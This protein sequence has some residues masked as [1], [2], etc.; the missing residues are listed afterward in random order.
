MPPEGDERLSSSTGRRCVLPTESIGRSW[1][2]DLERSERADLDRPGPVLQ[3]DWR[4][5]WGEAATSVHDG[6]RAHRMGGVG[7]EG[8]NSAY[9]AS[10]YARISLSGVPLSSSRITSRV[11]SMQIPHPRLM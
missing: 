1:D 10:M 9:V 7:V 11:M 4:Y 5:L 2:A 6:Y 8:P 3:V